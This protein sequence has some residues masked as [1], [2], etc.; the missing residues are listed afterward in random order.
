MADFVVLG[1]PKCGTSA[2]TR[3]IGTL[4][5]V[6]VDGYTGGELEAPYFAGEEQVAALRTLRQK[7]PH[8]AA[9]GHKFSAYVYDNAAIRRIASAVPRATLVLCV[10]DPKRALVSWREMHRRIAVQGSQKAHFVNISDES[11]RFYAEASLEDYYR[12]YARDWLTYTAHIQ[13]MRELVP[14]QPLVLVSQEYMAARMDKVLQVLAKRLNVPA[15]PA[16]PDAATAHRGVSDDVEPD[17]L[18]D[19]SRAELAAEKMKLNAL[20]DAWRGLPG[21]AVLAEAPAVAAR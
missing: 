17:D 19:E 3:A 2:L 12:R 20:L 14:L 10:R 21:V 1:F 18:S 16:N 15:P 6:Q 9:V 11:R 5:K 13:R 8:A 7:S 4:Q